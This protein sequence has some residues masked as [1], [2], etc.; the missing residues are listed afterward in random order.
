MR[1]ATTLTLLS[2]LIFSSSSVL[3]IPVPNIP[4]K[5]PPFSTNHQ[6]ADAVSDDLTSLAA[7]ELSYES[8]VKARALGFD[9]NFIISEPGAELH[10]KWPGFACAADLWN[11]KSCLHNSAERT[12]AVIAAPFQI[13]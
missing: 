13:P 10:P 9:T 3:A 6:A 7:R 8:T 1:F 11:P 5:S 4:L 12:F 2:A